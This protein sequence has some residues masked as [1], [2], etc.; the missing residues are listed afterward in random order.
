MEAI[1]KTIKGLIRDW[2]SKRQL[3]QDTDPQDLLEK[4]LNK[5]ELAHIQFHYFRNGVM[6]LKVDSSTRLYYL[7]L[8]KE[9]LLVKL[10]KHFR[11]AIKDVRFSI[12]EKR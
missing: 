12:G 6:G 8:K 7:S 4:A 11:S 10:R 9:D 3:H 2:E 1:N 5:K